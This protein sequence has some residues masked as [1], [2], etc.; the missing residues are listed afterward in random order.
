M[1]YGKCGI[2]GEDIQNTKLFEK[3]GSMYRG[4]IVRQYTISDT[5]D[6]Q[7]E[8]TAN[9]LGYHEFR[10]CSL[11]N[12]TKDADLDCLNKTILADPSF[13]TTRFPMPTNLNRT[14]NLKL[15]L[16][17]GFSCRNCV[18]QVGFSFLFA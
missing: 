1:N 14:L 10:V 15:A 2:C 12:R 8:V 3:G 9:H 6:V 7:I 11:D 18:F 5:I 16:P 4:V 13:K 17:P